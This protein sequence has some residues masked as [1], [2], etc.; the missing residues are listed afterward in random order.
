LVN[1]FE[2][3]ISSSKEEAIYTDMHGKTTNNQNDKVEYKI[4]LDVRKLCII[5]CDAAE[6]YY[7]EHHDKGKFMDHNISIIVIDI[8]KVAKGIR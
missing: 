5:L 8:E 3:C 1:K 4:R 2:L 7:I 6:I